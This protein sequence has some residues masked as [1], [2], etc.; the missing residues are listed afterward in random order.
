MEIQETIHI[1]HPGDAIA[2][3]DQVLAENGFAQDVIEVLKAIKDALER[4]II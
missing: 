1:G 4:G 3:L 2:L